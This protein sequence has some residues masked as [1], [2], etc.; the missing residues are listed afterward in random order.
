MGRL[1]NILQERSYKEGT[2]TLKSGRTSNFYI[3]VRQ[4]S[5]NP[6]GGYRSGERLYEFIRKSFPDAVA[7]AGVADAGIPL[8][9]SVMIMSHLDLDTTGDLPQIL[10]RKQAKEHGAAPGSR[11]AGHET[12]PKGSEVVLVEDVVTTG[13]SSVS[14]A[15]A[16]EDAGFEVIGI[17]AVVDRQE[18]ARETI[19]QAGYDFESIFT[20]RDI[21]GD[22]SDE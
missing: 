2:F 14:A 10:V 11:L 8:A 13:G 18:G 17:I 3:D 20:K 4:T 19:E 22:I 12:I 7:V 16:L 9:T 15:D 1:R 6:E 5:L 21:R